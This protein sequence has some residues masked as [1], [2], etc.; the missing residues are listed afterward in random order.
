MLGMLFPVLL[1][2]WFNVPHDSSTHSSSSEQSFSTHSITVKPTLK[3][4]PTLEVEIPWEFNE[5]ALPCYEECRNS[6]QKC[7]EKNNLTAGHWLPEQESKERARFC[8]NERIKCHNTCTKTF[9]NQIVQENEYPNSVA[10][11]YS[12]NIITPN[13][14]PNSVVM[15]YSPKK[16]I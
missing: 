14:Y 2:I 4:I 11:P 10:T 12:P 9:G 1:F 3:P 16:I 5:N 13:Y 15:P 6:L 7:H 8:E